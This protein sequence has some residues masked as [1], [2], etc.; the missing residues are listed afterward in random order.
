MRLLH[1]MH[2]TYPLLA[3]MYMGFSAGSFEGQVVSWTV[4]LIKRCIM[5]W[6]RGII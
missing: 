5:R 2:A 6:R 1:K 3:G 4:S